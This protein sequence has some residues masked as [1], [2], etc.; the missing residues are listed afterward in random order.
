M[1]ESDLIFTRKKSLAECAAGDV[2]GFSYGGKNTS[3]GLHRRQG[4]VVEVR[5]TKKHPISYNTKASNK[6]QRSRFL[7]TVEDGPEIGRASCRESLGCR[8]KVNHEQARPARVAYS[9]A[10]SLICTFTLRR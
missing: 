5:D 3:Q 8:V 7:V 6:I 10:S 2:V 9:E 4:K 1:K